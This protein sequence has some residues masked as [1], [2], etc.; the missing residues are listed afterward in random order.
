VNAANLWTPATHD[1]EPASGLPTSKQERELGVREGLG[2]PVVAVGRDEGGEVEVEREAGIVE[3]HGYYYALT[4]VLELGEETADAPRPAVLR[5]IDPRIEE[6]YELDGSEYLLSVD[7]GAAYSALRRN[8]DAIFAKGGIRHATKYMSM[9]SLYLSEPLQPGKIPLVLV[10][11]LASSPVTWGEPVSDF[12]LDS[13]IAGGY[14]FWFFAYSTALPF[15]YSAMLLRRSLLEAMERLDELGESPSNDRVVMIGHSMGG[16]L[17]RMQVTDTGMALWDAVFSKPPE[18]MDLSPEDLDLATSSLIVE[19]LPFVERVIFCSTPHRGSKYAANRVG[20]LGASMV[21]LPKELA[22]H[23]QRILLSESDALSGAEAERKKMPDSV[24]T[25]Q[26]EHPLVVALN[27][28]PIDSD[29]AYH[30]IVGDRGRGD[31][32]D[33]SDGVV[34]YSSSHLDGAASEKVVPSGH[35]SHKSPEGIAE[36][37]RVLRLHLDEG[38]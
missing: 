38:D 15:P 21:A 13:Q 37:M 20:K 32:P 11:G 36:L 17:T 24:Q 16:L 8:T 31:S 26:P 28:L 23:G 27:T 3:L 34:P 1:F 4:A 6:S 9:T 35:A 30:T 10:H 18:E 25:L 12:L 22:S 7:F 5:L 2:V 19:P 29:V 14:Q 33:S